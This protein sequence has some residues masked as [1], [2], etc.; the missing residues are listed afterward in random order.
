MGD[1]SLFAPGDFVLMLE[2]CQAKLHRAENVIAEGFVEL[3]LN[4]SERL[5]LSGERGRNRTFNLLI[6]SQLLCQLSYAPRNDST[7]TA[8]FPAG[9]LAETASKLRLAFRPVTSPGS[10]ESEVSDRFSVTRSLKHSRSPGSLHRTIR[11]DAKT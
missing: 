1:G 11:L 3:L 6:K 8:E 10:G 4:A 7:A 9:S 2:P 5:G